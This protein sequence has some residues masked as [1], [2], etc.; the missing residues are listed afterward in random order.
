MFRRKTIIDVLPAY[1]VYLESE[2]SATEETIKQRTCL[3][4]KFHTYFNRPLSKINQTLVQEYLVELKK[5]VAPNTVWSY[6]LI[7][8]AFFN[9]CAHAKYLKASP[10]AGMKIKKPPKLNRPA[11]PIDELRARLLAVCDNDRERLVVL[12]FSYTGCRAIEVSRLKWEDISE[13]MERIRLRGK[14]NKD[15]YLP[16]SADLRKAL[17]ARQECIKMMRKATFKTG[18][19]LRA[20][21]EAAGDYVITSLR[22]RENGRHNIKA[23]TIIRMI[24][25][26][27]ARA[28]LEGKEKQR[29]H[30]FRR[31][32]ATHLIR[33]TG[34]IEA[35]KEWLGHADVVTTALY[36]KCDP[37]RL[38]EMA[39][40]MD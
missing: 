15:R 39:A 25:Q 7:L 19:N 29:S 13:G 34:D 28:G 3:L 40:M 32:V 20:D 31:S 37:E 17:E 27:A 38:K 16:I 11:M 18:W 21:L 35:V 23:A 14:G 12:L 33:E 26:I 1:L 10:M 36:T 30:D 2:M 9:W 5:T 22:H 24:T 6:A 4:P 8:R